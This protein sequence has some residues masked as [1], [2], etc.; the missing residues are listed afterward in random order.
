[1]ASLVKTCKTLGGIWVIILVILSLFTGFVF[2]EAQAEK[3]T[4]PDPEKTFNFVVGFSAGGGTDLIFRAFAEEFKKVTGQ[5]V[6]ITNIPGG[7]SAVGTNEL[8]N[9]EADGYMMLGA[10]TH[11]VSATLQGTTEGFKELDHIAS[12]NWDPFII[13]VNKK[14][15]YT[16]FKE[17]VEAAETTPG[18]IVLGNSGQTGATGVASIGIN[19]N[20]GKTFN[21]TSFNGGAEL[22]PAVLGGHAEAGIFSQSEVINNL[23]G[24]TPLV[25]LTP[26]RSIKSELSDVPTLAECG[27]DFAVPGGSFR[28]ICVKKGTSPEREQYLADMAEKAF[29]SEGFQ[30]FMKEKGL[31]PFFKKLED[32]TAYDQTLIDAYTPILK[33]AGLYK[34]N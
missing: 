32:Y 19:L 11:T 2:A 8:L 7:S 22:I 33:E 30:S 3:Q 24:L 18:T 10:G 14:S 31:I 26:D 1:L 6:I 4:F 9:G 16:T 21:V 27:Y 25:I 34:M 29:N 5:N 17:L 23:D 13:A 20:F 15:P 12:L 28:A